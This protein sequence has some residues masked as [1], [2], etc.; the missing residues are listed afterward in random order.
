[1]VNQ[2]RDAMLPIRTLLMSLVIVG[3]VAAGMAFAP[4]MSFA[5]SSGQSSTDKT[6][7]T[8]EDVS[9]WTQKQ[10]NAAKAKWVKE[11]DK[12]NNCNKQATDKKLSGRKSW[13]FIYSCMTS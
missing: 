13:S 11:K 6:K 8:A 4:T 5:Q 2:E 1:M 3:A 10:W 7:S 12:W 9:K